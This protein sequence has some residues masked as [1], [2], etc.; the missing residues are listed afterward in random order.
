M[1][2]R[3]ATRTSTCDRTGDRHR[4]R[5]SQQPASSERISRAR[6][7][8]AFGTIQADEGFGVRD[9]AVVAP[10]ERLGQSGSQWI[11]ISS[12][13][14]CACDCRVSPR[15]IQR[16]I[17]SVKTPGE[18]CI[19]PRSVQSSRE[20]R[21]ASS[22]SSRVAV[23]ER[24]LAGVDLSGRELPEPPVGRMS[25]LTQQTYAILLV[26]GNHGSTAG[27]ADDFELNL[28]RRGSP[29]GSARGHGDGLD[30]D[31]DH[32]SLE[33][34]ARVSQ[35]VLRSW[36]I[37]RSGRRARATITRQWSRHPKQLADEQTAGPDDGDGPS[38]AATRIGRHR[39]Q[40]LN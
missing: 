39:R 4:D 34:L 31:I 13:C 26:Q 38:G 21:P 35:S 36:D 3:S 22:A 15:A 1:S 2:I 23:P 7:M 33:R 30:R 11:S 14:S 12:S 32:P 17:I 6:L 40:T 27:M 5:R 9:L 20:T 18:L 16:W 28:L 37:P 29:G 10:V 24:S 19:R 8:I 25:K